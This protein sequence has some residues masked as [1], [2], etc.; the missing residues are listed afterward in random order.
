MKGMSPPPCLWGPDYSLLSCSDSMGVCSSVP[1][2]GE[3]GT[4]D[5]FCC[6]LFS[7][8]AA[9]SAVLQRSLADFGRGDLLNMVYLTYLRSGG[10]RC[11]CARTRLLLAR[12]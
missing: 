6:C 5:A 9:L 12:F 3:A 2:S 1:A 7:A 4:E 10:R 11:S 8:L